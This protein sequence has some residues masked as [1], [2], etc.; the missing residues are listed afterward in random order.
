VKQVSVPWAEAGSRFTALFEAIAIS[1]LKVA[2]LSDVARILKIS[3]EE[4][5]GIMERAVKRGLTRLVVSLPVRAFAI[6]ETSFQKRHEYVRPSL[7]I[8]KSP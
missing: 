6:D 4:A 3:W 8:Y 2:S 5:S 7:P 1:L